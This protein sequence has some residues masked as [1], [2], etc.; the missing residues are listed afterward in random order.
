MALEEIKLKILVVDQQGSHHLRSLVDLLNEGGFNVDFCSDPETTYR[1]LKN[2]VRPVD[3][4]IIDLEC[5]QDTDGF[6]FLKALKEQDFCRAVKIIVTTNSV[7][8]PRLSSSKNSLGI[9][10][11]FN[12]ARP[13]EELFYIVADVTP[14]GF[15]N[16][17]RSR[18]VPVRI[19]VN[20]LVNGKAQSHYASNLSRDGIFI[21]NSEADPVGTIADV[22]FNLPGNS[23]LTLQAKA[24]V[25]RALRY[26]TNVSSLRYETFPPGNGLVF[27]DM[28]DEHRQILKEF[29]DRE[30]A[31]I[32]GFNGRWGRVQ[33]EETAEYIDVSDF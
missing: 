33:E 8:D 13:F 17:R 11:F 3:L 30:E 1:K 6:L 26:H 31:R 32:F 21:R 23:S 24:K 18:R 22:S 16:L 5:V 10:A 27:T 29:V 7:L 28:T 15:Q 4:L 20:Y 25:V 19:L 12:K 2:S 14:P 9:C